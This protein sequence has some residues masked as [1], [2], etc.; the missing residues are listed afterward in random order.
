MIFQGKYLPVPELVPFRLT[1][2]IIDGMGIAGTEGVFRRC[3][4]ETLRV[5]RESAD[6]IRTVLEVFKYDPLH[7]W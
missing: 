1:A 3:S 4:E 5:L 2:D 7:S 6:V